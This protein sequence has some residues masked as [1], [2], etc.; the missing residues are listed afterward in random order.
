MIQDVFIPSKIGSYYIFNKRVLGFEITTTSVQASLV[1][2]SKRKI[3]LENSM[4][5][6]LQDS[7]PT[8][9][10]NAIKKIATTIGSYDEVVT[11]LSSSAVI[12]KE[13]TLPF[14]GREKINMI[15]RYEVEPL[16][17]FSL[18]D[19]VVDFIVTHEDKES[20][21]STI[22]VAATRKSDLDTCMDHFEKAGVLVTKITLDMF[23]LYDFY[24]NAM[25][26]A[27]A[28]TS[29]LLV[30]FS[31][32]AI[33]IL[34]IQKGILK[35]VRLVPYGLLAMIKKI[36][37][38]V[39]DYAPMAFEDLLL[40]H[41]EHYNPSQRHQITELLLVDF[42]KQM[43][44]SLAFFQK[45]IK[46]FIAPAKI[47]CLG[48]GT[49]LQGF[50]D[51]TI[52]LLDIPVETLDIKRIAVR[53]NIEINRKVKTDGKYS[54]SLILPLAAADY[55]D[56]NFLSD[57]EQAATSRLFKQQLAAILLI[58]GATIAGIYFYSNYQ[59]K[60][61][62]ADYEKSKKQMVN[63][64]KDQMDVEIKNSKR[65]PD[66][67]AAADEK[68]QQTKKVCLSFDQTVHNNYLKHL[69]QL[70]DSI[71][72]DSIGLKLNKMTF[73]DKEIVL[74]G[75]ISSS[76][77]QQDAW[78]NL[79]IFTQELIQLQGFTLKNIPAE[80]AFNVTLVVKEDQQDHKDS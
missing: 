72:R 22:L 74:Q 5:I 51:Q 7:N 39:L 40:E 9:L 75:K 3:I 29:L 65:V 41:S 12:C 77:N 31:L 35:S 43:S 32:D 44:L 70:F 27:H 64:I 60:L 16:L 52:Q 6:T 49:Q 19:A 48:A 73:T 76:S 15:V 56:V 2:F 25:Y 47:I 46:N 37:Q 62:N 14:L 38:S 4:H 67:V 11:S 26:V 55:G 71:D 57:K 58:C 21:Q 59:L 1:Y 69:Q 50:A 78:V 79:D 13:L 30:D 45:Q 34:Y 28:Q 80:L 42:S 8:T 54:F 68:L 66:I 20:A 53:K 10:I 23:A 33:R 63:I 36:D 61:W 24:R 17:P 18:D